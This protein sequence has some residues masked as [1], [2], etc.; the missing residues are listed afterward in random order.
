[1][2]SGL[3]C[4]LATYNKNSISR[5]NDEIKKSY[6]TKKIC[7]FLNIILYLADWKFN[8]KISP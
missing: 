7:L 5:G 1:M 8:K 3:L 4:R 2:F 6:L